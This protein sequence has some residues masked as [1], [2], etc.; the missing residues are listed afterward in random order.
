MRWWD[1]G[2]DPK[3]KQ[4]WVK[5]LRS[6]RYHQGKG[7][8]VRRTEGEDRFCPLGVLANIT[9]GFDVVPKKEYD[10]HFKFI[11]NGL[12]SRFLIDIV[13]FLNGSVADASVF[14]S[15][16]SLDANMQLGFSSDKP[17]CVIYNDADPS[18]F[19]PKSSPPKK[20]R[21]ISTSYSSN[22]KK[23]FDTINRKENI[24]EGFLPHKHTKEGQ[25]K[26]CFV[27]PVS[28]PLNSTSIPF[29]SNSDILAPLP[30][31]PLIVCKFL[32]TILKYVLS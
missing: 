4:K 23:G 9:E 21:I 10:Y 5:A 30:T 20:L 18:V 27:S 2:L 8:L 17:Y 7:A 14:Q 15:T 13:Y 25:I 3:V 32:C 24:I 11:M 6:G 16:Y 19:F 29:D 12:G 28:Q 1:G 26:I 22:I 31:L